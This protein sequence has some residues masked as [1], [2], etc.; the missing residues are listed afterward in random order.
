VGLSYDNGPRS[1]GQPGADSHAHRGIGRTGAAGWSQRSKTTVNMDWAGAPVP[2][3]HLTV[4]RRSSPTIVTHLITQ[5][6]RLMCTA[7]LPELE[8]LLVRQ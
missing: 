4:T 2:S 5:A 1:P 7:G 8:A 6:R 3:V